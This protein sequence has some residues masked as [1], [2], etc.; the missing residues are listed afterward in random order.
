ML[1]QESFLEHQGMHDTTDELDETLSLRDLPLYG[2]QEWEED[3]SA[4]S[5]G[6]TSMSS[7][8]HHDYFEFFSHAPCF[9]PENIIFCGKII[10]YKQPPDASGT[11]PPKEV[12]TKQPTEKRSWSMFRWRVGSK[13]TTQTSKKASKKK[14]KSSEQGKEYDFPLHKMPILTSS[15]SGKARWFLF[16]TGI[17]RVSSKMELRDIKSRQS[18]RHSPIPTPSPTLK[19]QSHE[20]KVAGD[21]SRG[22]SGLWEVV[23]VLSCGGNS[24]PNAMVVGSISCN[25]IEGR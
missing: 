21:A 16:L 2:V 5:Q 9:P 20:K 25:R 13:S 18:H 14:H 4:D 23:R 22:S 7:D 17:S 24:D 6:S 19:F 3:L 11:V 10:P 8:D 12:D 15:P 1:V